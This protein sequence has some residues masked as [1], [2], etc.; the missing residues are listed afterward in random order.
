MRTDDSWICVASGETPTLGL[1]ASGA[2]DYDAI[3]VL[4]LDANGRL[5]E[6]KVGAR[7]TGKGIGVGTALSCSDR[8]VPV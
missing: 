7:S 1:N 4:A 2:A 6:Q 3:G 8:S 5:N